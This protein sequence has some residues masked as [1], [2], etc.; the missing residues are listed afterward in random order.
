MAA[1]VREAHAQRELGIEHDAALAAGF[2]E[3]GVG[4]AELA[5]LNEQWVEHSRA[6][7]GQ[8]IQ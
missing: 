3:R 2:K 6:K 7:C 1:R 4:V 5:Q 8:R